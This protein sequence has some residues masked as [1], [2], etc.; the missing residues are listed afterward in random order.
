MNI[1]ETYQDKPYFQLKVGLSN[2]YT[3]FVKWNVFQD[4]KDN[5]QPVMRSRYILY[6]QDNHRISLKN[7]NLKLS[8][9]F[10]QIYLSEN[11]QEIIEMATAHN[12]RELFVFTHFGEWING[13]FQRMINSGDHQIIFMETYQEPKLK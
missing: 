11:D 4:K 8:V 12:H 3:M 7:L 13:D 2:G 5:N 9:T 1:F 6:D 10:K